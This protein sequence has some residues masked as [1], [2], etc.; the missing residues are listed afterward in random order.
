MAFKLLQ[1][2]LL[3]RTRVFYNSTYLTSSTVGK[4][5]QRQGIPLAAD[6]ER[7][8]KFICIPNSGSATYGPVRS[9]LN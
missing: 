2:N 4:N 9:R 6:K 3:R 5:E 7:K 8:M 1:P